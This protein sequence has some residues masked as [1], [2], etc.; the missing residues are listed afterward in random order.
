LLAH[1]FPECQKNLF[2][3]FKRCEKFGLYEMTDNAA[4]AT[5]KISLTICTFSYK[6]SVLTFPVRIEMRR[7]T[8]ID[9]FSDTLIVSAQYRAASKPKSP[10]HLLDYLLADFRRHFPYKSTVALFYAAP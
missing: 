2:A 1:H 10:F 7:N 6:N 8:G 5:V 4:S 9:P 3:E